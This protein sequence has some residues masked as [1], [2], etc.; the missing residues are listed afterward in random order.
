MMFIWIQQSGKQGR[1][2]ITYL[3]VLRKLKDDAGVTDE[4]RQT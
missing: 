4:D 3:E 1:M 2:V